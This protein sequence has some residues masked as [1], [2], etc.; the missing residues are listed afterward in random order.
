M[1]FLAVIELFVIQTKS[2]LRP[3]IS[4]NSKKV[5]SLWDL[6]LN[7]N[8]PFNDPS[9]FITPFPVQE[10]YATKYSSYD[11]DGIRLKTLLTVIVQPNNRNK[12]IND[13]RNI[14]S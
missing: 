8:F 12:L 1:R 6:K 5:L 7:G 4:L 2:A 14:Q 10:L 3:I 11:L 9:E 13:K